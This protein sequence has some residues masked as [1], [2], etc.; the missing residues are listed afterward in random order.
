MGA[1]VKPEIYISWVP[2]GKINVKPE[3]YVSWVPTGKI[4]VKPEVYATYVKA[5]VLETAEADILR[6]IQNSENLVGDS[7]RKIVNPEENQ[8]DL[9]RSIKNS[10]IS[11]KDSLRE[12]TQTQTTGKDT[13]RKITDYNE[14]TGDFLRKIKA[15]TTT[16]SDTLR[17]IV[18][19]ASNVADTF[20]KIVSNERTPGDLFREIKKFEIVTAD[21]SRGTGII[22]SEFDTERI[23]KNDTDISSDTIREIKIGQSHFGDTYRKIIDGQG[24]VS[25]TLRKVNYNIDTVVTSDLS[26]NI[27]IIESI[28]ADFL[29]SIQNFEIIPSDTLREVKFYEITDVTADTL[30]KIGK[31]QTVETDTSRK[32][33]IFQTA[34]ADTEIKN[35]IGEI[36]SGD[37]VRGLHTVITADIELKIVKAEIVENDTL[38]RVPHFLKYCFEGN[39]FG[40]SGRKLLKSGERNFV[41]TFKDYAIRQLSI[42]LNEKTFSDTFQLETAESIDIQES[43]KGQLLDYPIS[44][45]AEETSQ[46]E[47]FQTVKGMYDVD[48]LLYTQ[49]FFTKNVGGIVVGDNEDVF[50]TAGAYVAQIANYFGLDANIKIQ[51]FTPYHDF[52]SSNITYSDLIS[53]V[54]GWTSR[55]PKRQINVF[56][57]GNTLQCIQR[58]MEENVFDI[59]ELPHTRPTV[60]R[61]LIRTLWNNS[62]GSENNSTGEVEDE[63]SDLND[64]AEEEIAVPFNGTISFE[65]SGVSTSRSYKNG[66]LVR[67]ITK[68]SNSKTDSTTTTTYEYTEVFADD[69][70]QISIF[71]HK[72][73][74]DFYLSSKK[75][76]TSAMQY[77]KKLGD[78]KKI[79]TT[80]QTNYLYVKTSGGDLYLSEEREETSREEYGYKQVGTISADEKLLEWELKEDKTSVRQTF[81][82][83]IG[84][85]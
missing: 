25:D 64:F 74:G 10:E 51:E 9:T 53:T 32:V 17:K 80:S 2:T 76:T 78:A 62:F 30:R 23:L 72:L 42:T 68:T 60:D 35:G 61:K 15:A 54:F 49:I 38:I 14:I 26:R 69:V 28:S 27:K 8:G 12:V 44:F 71:L 31:V 33:K 73:V 11:S 18:E 83:P 57:R 63:I 46:T 7:V 40:T 56:I 84:N 21:T 6:Q 85:G 22:V 20:R 48:K 29:R 58:G 43:V 79:E 36:F 19:I 67:E 41:N 81:H 5:A 75:T 70:S 45:L 1:T 50:V 47:L 52:T 34:E 65:D 13:F 24:S 77:G 39:L 3:I 16:F 82:T 59:T 37:T 4:F 66:L 55:V